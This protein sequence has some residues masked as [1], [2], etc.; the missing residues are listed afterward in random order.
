M[1]S[2]LFAQVEGLGAGHDYGPF[3]DSP[4]P[5]LIGTTPLSTT[6]GMAS[7]G[8]ASDGLQ[9][10]HGQ[11]SPLHPQT[12]ESAAS[13]SSVP[14][15]TSQA[16]SSAPSQAQNTLNGPAQP[17][18]FESSRERNDWNSMMHSAMQVSCSS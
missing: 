15:S 3:V 12:T 6:T 10:P 16:F 18:V 11:N 1:G 2:H 13:T 8:A 9:R 5:T 7:G 4:Q 14:A 17:P